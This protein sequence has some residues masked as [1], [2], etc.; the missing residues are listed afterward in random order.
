ME[1][2]NNDLLANYF[3]SGSWVISLVIYLVFAFF[4]SRVFT[5][6]GIEA[7]KGWVPFVNY[8]HIYKLGGFSGWWI[9]INLVPFIGSIVALV[10]LWIAEYRIS[11]G[12]EKPGVF[13]LLA[14]FL[15]IIW[16]GILAFDSSKWRGTPES[17]YPAKG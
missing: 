15:Q 9:L 12:F 3:A 8:F 1:T 13:V 5:K 6:A 7:W 16:T 10:I 2:Y 17:S 14:I 4:L 11:K